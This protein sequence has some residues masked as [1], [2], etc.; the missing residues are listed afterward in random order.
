[1]ILNNDSSKV[2]PFKTYEEQLTLLKEEKSLT[3]NNELKALEI[4]K[5]KNYYR[6]S[7]Y[8]LTLMKD[9]KFYDGVT[10]DNVY[11]LYNFDV[12]LRSFIL[13][14]TAIIETYFK[15]IIAYSHSQSYSPLGYLDYNNFDNNHFFDEFIESVERDISR[16]DDAFVAHHKTHKNNTY[17]FWVITE[18][19]TF[20]DLSKLYKNLKADDRQQIS[21]STVNV[22][23]VYLENWLQAVSVARNIAAHN[24]RFYNRKMKS[25]KIKLPN[26]L[27]DKVENDS[28]FAYIFAMKKLL[29]NEKEKQKFIFE[30]ENLFKKHNFVDSKYLGFPKDWTNML[31]QF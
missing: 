10:F 21:K 22:G 23:R 17:P 15:A 3:I 25:V 5:C 12:D 16:S 18:T 7:A 2:K 20:G 1:M 11:E 27:K 28:V 8:F 24:G 26:G 31:N 29:Y 14:Y 6:I 13:S 30:L 9:G 19:L 4:L